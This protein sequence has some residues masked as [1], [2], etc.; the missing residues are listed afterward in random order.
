MEAHTT[1][2]PQPPS[3][4]EL[5]RLKQQIIISQ[6]V[7]A[8]GC[9]PDQALSLLQTANWDSQMA[10]SLFFQEIALPQAQQ[11]LG[12]ANT[13]ATPNLLPDALSAFAALQ[14]GSPADGAGGSMDLFMPLDNCVS[15][16]QPQP[17]NP[18]LRT[19][20]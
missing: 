17:S 2:E 8:A 19:T 16:Q 4:E 3:Q 7:Q 14:T 1:A 15:A 5:L 13:P 6:V 10:M 18:F 9:T 11:H 20:N 12:P